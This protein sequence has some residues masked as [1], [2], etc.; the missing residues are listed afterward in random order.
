MANTINKLH[1]V[2]I[3]PYIELNYKD[4]LT[5][6]IDYEGADSLEITPEIAREMKSII[7][8]YLYSLYVKEANI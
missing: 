8:L 1:K 4:I 2:E 3:A 6:D 7:D 5:L